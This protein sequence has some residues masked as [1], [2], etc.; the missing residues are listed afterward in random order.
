MSKFNTKD[1]NNETKN[2][3]GGKAFK[4]S[5][6]EELVFASLT[7]FIEDSY[8][9]SK[10]KRLDRIRTLV[11]AIAEKDPLFVAK[12]AVVARKEFHM[13]SAFHV[14]IGELARV[15]RG[16]S[17]IE[18]AIMSGAE[19]PDDLTEIISYLGKP[20][21]NGVK[22]G[23]RK[24]LNKF[25]RYQL[26]KYRSEDKTWKLVDVLNVT[27]PKPSNG[28][29]KDYADLMKGELVNTET[30]EARLSSG[31]DKGEVWKDMLTNGKLGYMALLRN[32]RNIAAQ[33]DY[34]TVRLAVEKL[35]NKEAVLKSK[36]LPFRFLSAYNAL[37]KKKDAES[38]ITFEKD[39]D[40]VGLLQD[41]ITKAVLHS[42][43]NIP[44]LYGRTMILSDNSG[45][46]H[47]DGHGA[48]LVSAMSNV[49]TADIANLFAVLYWTRADNTFVGL[50]GDRL[51]VPALDRS[52]SLF[53]N[54]K[55][56]NEESTKCGSA[57]EKGIF[58]AFRTLINDR[59]IVDRIV[60]FSDCQ[61]GEGCNWYGPSEKASD[62]NALAAQYK[63]IN[64]N[65]RIYSID[66]KGHGNKMFSASSDVVLLSGWSDKI[67]NLMEIVEKKEGLVKWIDQ[68]PVNL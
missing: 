27:K 24:A 17:I 31:E 67:F 57:T 11:A 26:A 65:A 58:D 42:V 10:D 28:Q 48:S 1:T 66:L 51:I 50:F 68:Y 6:E 60:V 40:T 29:S 46:M 64:P 59:T 52:K 25:D 49:K 53:D 16:D 20:I 45:S 23:V 3:M 34:D 55:I 63:V 14:L 8:Y 21:P 7:T 44:L 5:S 36:Q 33:A 35:I 4:H 18:N 47:G 54:F 13:R 41:A 37:D 39:K 62:F 61:V 22:D 9:E 19:R 43:E 15:H 2:Y 38:G 30:W 56:I 12:L 32:L